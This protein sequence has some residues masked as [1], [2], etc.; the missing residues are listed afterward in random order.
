MKNIE[1]TVL[2]CTAVLCTGLMIGIF[3]GRFGVSDSVRLSS[4]DRI[5]ASEPQQ[6]MS[7]K[8]DTVGK[9][10]INFATADELTM[11]PGIG[12]TYAER[13]VAYRQ[14]FGPFLNIEDLTKVKGIGE[15][16]FEA[17][18]EYITVGE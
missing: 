8:S 18:K 7:Y 6:T 4:Y 2:L 14:K 1:Q 12:K 3:I 13:I 10:N 16:R 17:I 5:C 11:L 9:I 15:T